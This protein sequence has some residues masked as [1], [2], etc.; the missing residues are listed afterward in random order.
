M[1]YHIMLHLC[2]VV[3]ISPHALPPLLV[4]PPPSLIFVPMDLLDVPSCKALTPPPHHVIAK[5][6]FC[7]HALHMC[8]MF[9][10]QSFAPH[11]PWLMPFI[12]SVLFFFLFIHLS[13]DGG[14]AA[15]ASA[16]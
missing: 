16:T 12:P 15:M 1:L 4:V 13:M 7:M 9:C 2:N 3:V 6:E 10:A 5:P 14:A 11:L 8:N